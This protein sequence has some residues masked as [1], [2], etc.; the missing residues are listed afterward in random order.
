[1]NSFRRSL[2]A[3]S[4]P[5]LLLASVSACKG[6]SREKRSS[7]L[8][9]PGAGPGPAAASAT[10]NSAVIDSRAPSDSPIPAASTPPVLTRA[11]SIRKAACEQGDAA[12]CASLAIDF[13]NGSAGTPDYVR[14]AQY[15]LRSCEGG[16]PNGCDGLGQLYS[17]GVGVPRDDRRAVEY[18]ERSCRPGYANGCVSL[19]MHVADGRGTKKDLPRAM[20]LWEDGCDADI[21]FGCYNAGLYYSTGRGEIARNDDKARAFFTRA[22]TG[23]KRGCDEQHR[24]DWCSQLGT[25]YEEGHGMPVDLPRA[26]ALHRRACEGNQE[27][28]CY[29][30]ARLIERDVPGA[31]KREEARGFY[32]KGCNGGIAASCD[33]ADRLNR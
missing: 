10:T 22:A 23:F 1:M 14:A 26:I 15:Y 9:G 16:I 18:Y 27:G 4:V 19:A 28:S 3:L 2:I 5:V 6:T 13:H 25:M 21:A 32:E 12:E 31:G 11:M 7:A 24:P 20:K 17:M 8:S 29:R 30:L 33:A